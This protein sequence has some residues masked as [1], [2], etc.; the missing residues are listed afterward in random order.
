MVPDG[1]ANSSEGD[2]DALGLIVGLVVVGCALAIGAAVVAAIWLRRQRTRAAAADAANGKGPGSR[3]TSGG[4]RHSNKSRRQSRSHTSTTNNTYSTIVSQPPGAITMRD[5]LDTPSAASLERYLISAD[6]VEFGEVLGEG[7]FGVVRRGVWRDTHVAIKQMKGADADAR[8]ALITECTKLAAIRPHANIITFFGVMLEPSLS[9]V[10][11]YAPEGVLDSLLASD[12]V[13]A[14]DD[15]HHILLGVA[16]GMSHLHRERVV[17]R[18]LAARNVLLDRMDG[19][20]SAKVADF[21]LAR[22]SAIEEDNQTATAVGPIKWMAPECIEFKQY[23]YASDVWA[24]GVVCY[25]VETRGL[26]WD[27]VYNMKVVSLVLGGATLTVPPS[28]AGTPYGELMAQC[29]RYQAKERPVTAEIVTRLRALWPAVADAVPAPSYSQSQSQSTSGP[30]TTSSGYDSVGS[31]MRE[32]KTNN[33][34]DVATSAMRKGTAPAVNNTYD[35]ASSV[36][37]RKASSGY[38]PIALST[39]MPEGHYTAPEPEDFGTSG[40]S[41]SSSYPRRPSVNEAKGMMM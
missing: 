1:A 5:R 10:I 31:S 21:G 29:W 33:T 13:L 20:L 26:P 4:G 27:G 3:E 32:V 22:D 8:S 41:V 39:R 2:E 38:S 34:Y 25:E 30:T 37:Q 36:V 23:S 14:P 24:F 7:N 9:V 28:V 11:A 35:V 17:H 15:L 12:A 16:A 40:R 18:D 6:E 19:R